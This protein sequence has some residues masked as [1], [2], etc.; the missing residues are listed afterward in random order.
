MLHPD[1]V[2]ALRSLNRATY[3]VSEEEDRVILDI[4]H[5]LISARSDEARRANVAKVYV[6]GAPYG[7]LEVETLLNCWKNRSVGNATDLNNPVA[8]L[9][10]IY[11]DDPG[12]H[13]SKGGQSYYIILDPERVLSE[14]ACV[15]RLL[16]IFHQLKADNR[17]IKCLIFLSSVLYIPPKLQTYIQ[18]VRDTHLGEEEVQESLDKIAAA[19]GK[20]LPNGAPEWFRGLT[21]FQM[22][23]AVTRSLVLT[24]K[25]ANPKRIDRKHIQDFKRNQINGTDLLNIVDVTD[26]SFDAVGGLDRFKAWVM[27]VRY[28]WTPAGREYGLKPPK[29][30]LAAGVWGCGKSL[31]IKAMGNAWGLPVIQLELGKI[32]SSGVGDTERN[33][34]RIISYLEAMAPCVAWVDEAEKS[35]SG[36]GSSNFSDAGTTAR[37]LGI[38][39][40]WHQETKAEVCLAMTVNSLSTLPIEFIN[41]IEDRFFFDLPDED[42]RVDIIKIHLASETRLT[43]E[44]IQEFPLRELAKAAEDLVPREMGQAVKAALWQSFVQDKPNLDPEIF[45]H[46]LQT[47]P[48]I[49]RTMEREVREVLDWVGWDPD[50]QEGVRARFA[51]SRQ[52]SNTL[53]LLTRGSKDR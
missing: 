8:A 45:R 10:K 14:P 51:S 9:D 42:A 25:D 22:E 46:E 37:T 12:S 13:T 24:R 3:V 41:R 6:V 30:I 27:G 28:A 5:N 40:T 4:Y 16:N 26:F 36:S 20:P 35:L 11:A 34:Y 48:R 23:A 49:L 52:S 39:S 15:R 31:S 1:L 43:A 19:I 32:R 33:T 2:T 38:L 44:E 47:R 29:G 53:T 50:I 17:I 7:I 18:V 21:H